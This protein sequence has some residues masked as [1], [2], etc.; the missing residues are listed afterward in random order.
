MKSQSDLSLA[1]N[2]IEHE[3]SYAESSWA[4]ARREL[5]GLPNGKGFNIAHEAVDRH[6]NG[7]GL[8]RMG[9]AKA[10]SARAA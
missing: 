1:P 8:A 10:T 3:E 9:R 7:V 5:N 6:A 2:L 4:E